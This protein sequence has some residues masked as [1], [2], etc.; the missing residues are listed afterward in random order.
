MAQTGLREFLT[1]LDQA[2]QL[3]RMTKPVDPRQ[4]S[5]LGSQSPTATMFETIDGYPEWR[6][7]TGL[8]SSRP[9]LAIAMGCTENRIAFEF[10]KKSANPIEPVIV[11][12][13]PC[14]EVVMQ[15]DDV[16]LTS[17]P[18]PLMHLFDGGPY[19]SGTFA[20]SRDPEYGSNAGSY[21]LMYRTPKETGIDLVSPS[22]MRFYYQRALDQ[23][24]PLPI[25]IAVGVHPLDM[26][27]AS[28]KAP[29]DTNEL[30]RAVKSG[31]AEKFT[32]DV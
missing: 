26:L 27:A 8:V 32:I 7:A 22:D 2:G 17:I 15:G 28:Y 31:G 23:G 12:N 20:V 16:D 14:Q 10:E 6:V 30:A 11:D 24:K 13:A 3:K 19:I 25:A 9:R 4:M 18:F 1:D 5:A 29:I 21:R